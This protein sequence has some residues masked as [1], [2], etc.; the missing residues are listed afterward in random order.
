MVDDGEIRRRMAI[1]RVGLAPDRKDQLAAAPRCFLRPSAADAG[2]S[3]ERQTSKGNPR[4]C[5]KPHGCFSLRE[6]VA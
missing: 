5:P 4:D 6:F 1:G 3:N 2:K